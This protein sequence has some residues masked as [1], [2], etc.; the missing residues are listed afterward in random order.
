MHTSA[1]RQ[2]SSHTLITAGPELASFPWGSSSRYGPCP[3]PAPSSTTP[4]PSPLSL[5]GTADSRAVPRDAAQTRA[6]FEKVRPTHVIHLAAMVGGLFRNIKYN[7]DFWVSEGAQEPGAASRNCWLASHTHVLG[8][9]RRSG[10]GTACGRRAV[11]VGQGALG[12]I[13]KAGELEESASAVHLGAGSCHLSFQMLLLLGPLWSSCAGPTGCSCVSWALVCGMVFWGDGHAV[14]GRR[15][16]E[17]CQACPSV[18]LVC[19]TPAPGTGMAEAPSRF[20]LGPHARAL[21]PETAF[22]AAQPPCLPSPQAS[23]NARPPHVPLPGGRWCS[24]RVGTAK[25]SFL[26]GRRVGERLWD[27]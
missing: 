10:L 27:G 21:L 19:F 16:M 12:L 3:A 15:R 2:T 17:R 11:Q 6:L 1:P 8:S 5:Q 14:R 24:G 23:P 25:A 20:C 22:S 4:G 7:L 9:P 18:G 26:L 13:E